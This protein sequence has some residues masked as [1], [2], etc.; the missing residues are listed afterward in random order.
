MGSESEIMLILHSVLLSRFVFA[1]IYMNSLNS[2][3]HVVF[4]TRAGVL[5]QKTRGEA[6]RVLDAD[7][8]RIASILN[9]LKNDSSIS[10]LA[11]KV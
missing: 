4:K 2:F 6:L 9:G 11:E 8:A 10:W 5:Y 7:K 1:C 3:F